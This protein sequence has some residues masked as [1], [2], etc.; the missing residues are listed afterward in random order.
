MK[1]GQNKCI[2]LLLFLV[3]LGI[4]CTA[5][6][7]SGFVENR[8]VEIIRDKWG[9]PHI[10]GKTDADVAYGL[11]WAQCEDDFTTLQEQ[12]L[13]IQGLSGLV[14]GKDG[15]ITDLGVKFMGL[16]EIVEN[17]MGS[18]SPDF[19]K[20]LEGFTNGINAYALSH[21]KEI[22]TKSLFPITSKSVVKSYLMALI[23]ITRARNDLEN[24]VSGDIAK[25]LKPDSGIGSNAFAISPK[26]TADGATYLVCNPHQPMEGWYSWYEAHLVSDEGWNMLGATFISGLSIFI[27]ANEH[28][29]WTHTLNY[30]DYSD[31]YQLEMHPSKK[32]RYRFDGEWHDLEEVKY[33]SKMRLLPGLK[34]PVSRKVYRSKYGPTFKTDHGFFAWHFNVMHATLAMEQ[35]WRMNKARSLSEFKAALRPIDIPST[36]II[37]ADQKGNIMLVSNGKLPI[38]DSKFDWQEILPGNT[39]ETL[40]KDFI[41]L[42]SLPQKLNPD[43]GYLF[44]TNNTPFNCT[45]EEENPKEPIANRQ[46][47]YQ[48]TNEDNIR[49][50]RFMELIAQYDKLSYEDLKRI[51]FDRT[52]SEQ[53]KIWNVS[54]D[55][56][57]ALDPAKYPDI[58]EEIILLKNWNRQNELDN[59]ETFL[60]EIIFIA[61]ANQ[62]ALNSKKQKEITEEQ[63]VK[64]I[65]KAGDFMRERF[66]KINPRLG[67]VQMHKRGN[68]SLPIA[69]G[70]VSLAAIDSYYDKEK[71]KYI[72]W[73]GESYIALIRFK[74]GKVLLETG[75]PYG[76][77]NRNDSPHY[78]DQMKNFVSQK[79]KPMTLDIIEV[80]KNASRIYHPLMMK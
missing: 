75:V 31:V 21:P 58:K 71:K 35:W 78:T 22:A 20:I 29:G 52:Y 17:N 26:K 67:D 3:S 23:E 39:S 36:N 48:A 40:W 72:P 5:Q 14:N 28:L 37:Y 56:I 16:E 45:C 62:G 43:C 7:P 32:G 68:V 66:G 76:S 73:S 65:K 49:A 30:A 34:I 11:A 59:T 47:G 6:D 60:F 42:D 80:R 51:K 13:A 61:L 18:F 41:P 24:I 74:N 38:R 63:A 1:K 57:F 10:Y 77:S 64:A 70:F 53:L 2:T 4:T 12:L 33:T 27:G 9:V 8:E 54:I 44:E 55:A 19:I 79:L 69:G 15:V 25:Q 46:M 50:L